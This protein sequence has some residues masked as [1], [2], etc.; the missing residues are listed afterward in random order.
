MLVLSG[1]I[2]SKP[3]AL[4]LRWKDR[5]AASLRQTQTALY[6]VT[7][8]TWGAIDLTVMVGGVIDLDIA[9]NEAG[10]LLFSAEAQPPSSPGRKHLEMAALERLRDAYRTFWNLPENR[11]LLSAGAHLL[12]RSPRDTAEH[13]FSTLEG[14]AW[15]PYCR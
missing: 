15:S 11:R 1:D 9:I 14:R 4:Q 10:V 6:E 7:S 2:L 8:K 3:S 12:V 5:H 13:I